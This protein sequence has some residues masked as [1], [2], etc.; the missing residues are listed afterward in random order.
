[1]IKDEELGKK[2][3]M[4]YTYSIF[5]TYHGLLKKNILPCIFLGKGEGY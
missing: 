3:N 5:A 4:K 2:I 1:M